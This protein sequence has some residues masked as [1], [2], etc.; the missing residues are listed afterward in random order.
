MAKPRRL[1]NIDP[2]VAV[3]ISDPSYADRE[4][5]GDSALVDRLTTY[6]EMKEVWEALRQLSIEFDD[7]YLP[8]EFM[9]L[10]VALPGQWKRMSKTS[11]ANARKNLKEI[12]EEARK[13]AQK[14]MVHEAD[15][16]LMAGV[17]TD[18]HSLIVALLRASGRGTTAKRVQKLNWRAI[19]RGGAP[20]I[21][22]HEVL[23]NALADK[24]EEGAKPKSR[25]RI[26]RPT[27]P[28]EASAERT[29]FVQQVAAYL[30]DKT[31]DQIKKAMLK[32]I[33]A[34]TVNVMVDDPDSTLTPRH[35]D[36]LVKL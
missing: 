34:A 14:M 13:L 26:D 6:A 4:A 19:N 36:L 18:P 28:N 12:A 11:T 16:R 29:Y 20:A 8:L 27:K 1:K 17:G 32:A 25:P 10:V 35:V 22:S 31:D 7:D 15:I 3:A 24:L 5:G 2:H 30:H 23:L 21:P 9:T 33:A